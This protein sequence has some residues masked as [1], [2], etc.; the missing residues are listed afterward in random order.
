MAK[1]K[2]SNCTSY[3]EKYEESLPKFKGS[4]E[5]KYKIVFVYS[6]SVKH[7]IK[8][9]KNVGMAMP[10]IRETRTVYMQQDRG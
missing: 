5:V 1:R 4:G 10:K 9:L 2:E 3:F 7:F 6:T 8:T